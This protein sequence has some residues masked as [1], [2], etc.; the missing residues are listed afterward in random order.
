MKFSRFHNFEKMTTSASA[1]TANASFCCADSDS[2]NTA[3]VVA[4]DAIIMASIIICAL[5]ALL[6]LHLITLLVLVVLVRLVIRSSNT[7]WH[8]KPAA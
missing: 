4:M 5:I 1:P 8:Y 6:D 2:A 7:H 3:I